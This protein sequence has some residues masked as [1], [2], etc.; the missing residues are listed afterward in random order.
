MRRNWD[1]CAVLVG[2]S[3]GECSRWGNQRGGS[4]KLTVESPPHNPAVLVDLH[5]QALKAGPWRDICLSQ[6]YSREPK[7]GRNPGV[8]RQFN[9]MR[10]TRAIECF[11]QPFKG[12]EILTPTTAWVNLE[13]IIRLSGLNPSQNNTVWFYLSPVLRA[14]HSLRQKVEQRLSGAGG[15]GTGELV[16]N[17]FREQFGRMKM[18]WRWGWSWLHND[19]KVFNKK[20]GSQD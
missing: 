15:G 8:H 2:T 6:H 12:K 1:S 14:S 18:F 17:G 20:N 19:A 16:F 3:N 4:Q 7:G 9:K 10:S 13:D 5:S 11:F